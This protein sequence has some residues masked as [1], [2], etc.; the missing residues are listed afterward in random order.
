MSPTDPKVNKLSTA[1]AIMTGCNES[2]IA[3][4][5]DVFTFG[6]TS[7]TAPTTAAFNSGAAP[8]AA[9]AAARLTV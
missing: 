7:F 6:R 9:L 3:S 1:K 4:E 5:R 2:V 8:E